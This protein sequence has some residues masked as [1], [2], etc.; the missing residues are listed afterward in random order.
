MPDTS[1][2]EIARWRLHNQHLTSPFAASAKD[3]VVGLLAVQAENPSQAAWAVACR[4][5]QPNAEDL[6]KLLD[7]GTVLRTH[8]LRTTWHFVSADDIGW[9]LDVTRPRVQR[10]TGEALHTTYGLDER[11]IDRVAKIV[12]DAL[13]ERGDRTRSE[14]GELLQH[15]GFT[16]HG[17][18]LMLLMAHLELDGLICSGRPADGEHSY[19]LLAERAPNTRR[20]DRAEALAELAVRYFTSHGPA[21]ERDLSYWAT[22]TVTDVRAGLAEVK[23]RLEQFEHDGRTYWHAPGDPPPS[24][25]QPRGHLLQILDESY[26]GYQDSRWVLDSAGVVPR[27]RETAIGMALVD[28]Q[29]VAG[30]KRTL[31]KDRVDFA[32][33]PFR[34]L[35]ADELAAL[36]ASADRYG[37]FLGLDARVRC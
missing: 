28:G 30:M 13:G 8:I 27:G 1:D 14:L 22:L 2:R 36:H 5:E 23:D 21:T 19:A 12:L 29:M 4:T 31:A 34:D 32:L 16:L 33:S 17:Q 7:D 26:R 15:N 6:A 18:L 3:V 11:A 24:G 9:L 10:L 35:A 25:Q 37:A 20:L